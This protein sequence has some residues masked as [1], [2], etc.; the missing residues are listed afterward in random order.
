H[1]G[2]ALAERPEAGRRRRQ[3]DAGQPRPLRRGPLVLVRPVRHQ[4]PVRRPRVGLDEPRHPGRPREPQLRGLLPAG[5]PYR[6]G[7]RPQ[8]G[9][10][11]GP[12]RAAP[13]VDLTAARRP[14]AGTVS[15][16]AAAIPSRPIPLA[17]AAMTAPPRTAFNGPPRP[18]NRLV[19][20]ITAAA[21]AY[22]T[23]VPP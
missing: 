21:T 2:G 12:P 19:P 4:H 14:T 3:G 1:P 18:P 17:M 7:R 6:W 5:W 23:R 13:A 15:W 22:S 16:L 10:A 11:A 20:P 9:P 8:P